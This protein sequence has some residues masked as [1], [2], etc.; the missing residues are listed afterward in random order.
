KT[1]LRIYE[2]AN[3]KMSTEP[4]GETSLW[5]YCWNLTHGGRK[6]L[7]DEYRIQMTTV[8]SPLPMNPGGQ[9]LLLGYEPEREVFA[10]FDLERHR[11]FTSGSPSVQ[12]SISTLNDCLQDG[13]AFQTK[14]NN[15]VA[16]GVRS[17]HLLFYCE[18]A[19]ELHGLGAHSSYVET[20]ERVVKTQDITDADIRDLPQQRRLI[21][22]ETARWSRSSTFTKQVLNAYDNRCAVTRRKLRLVDAAHILPV[23]AGDQSIDYIRNGIALSPTYHRA[24]DRGLI[25]LD[26]SMVMRLNSSA[27]DDL[28]RLGL[29][30]GIDSFAA[31]LGKIHLP[32][33]P[34]QH[35]DPYFIRLA[36]SYRGVRG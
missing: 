8:E 11:I 21:M 16:I 29:D 26:E 24:F 6:S 2:N 15:E 7:P 12:V 23:K 25:F 20:V 35:P 14:S 18:H 4:S 1:I 30:S 3:I 13:L 31:Q 22:R 10:G 27:A 17:D 9:T 19:R 34:E 28:I 36:N 5:V 33:N 32:Y